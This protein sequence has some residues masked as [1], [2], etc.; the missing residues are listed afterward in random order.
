MLSELFDR[1]VTMNDG[2]GQVRILDVAMRQR[3]P[4]D[5]VISTLHVQR[6][7]TSSLGFTRSGETL[8]VDVTEVSGL[9]K[10]DSN[11]AAT[12]LLAVH[13]RHAS[14]RPGRLHPHACPRTVRWRSR[15]S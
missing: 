6:V 5:W 4:K 15:S 9:L 11:Q 13:G 7:R 3:R 1:V 2:S 14:R 8:T 12:A 10:T